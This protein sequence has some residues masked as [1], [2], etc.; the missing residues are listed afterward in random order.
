VFHGGRFTVI[1]LVVALTHAN[2]VS[3]WAAPLE[4]RFRGNAEFRNGLVAEIDIR[5][6]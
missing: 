2:I 5:K 6:L 1:R 4:D 3:N